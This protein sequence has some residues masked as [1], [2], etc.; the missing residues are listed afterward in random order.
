MPNHQPRPRHHPLYGF[1]LF[2]F[3]Y[4]TTILSCRARQCRWQFQLS[5]EEDLETILGEAIIH[6]LE[7]NHPI[8]DKTSIKSSVLSDITIRLPKPGNSS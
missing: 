4:T 3:A 7:C 2:R 6:R 1:K 8:Q 5:Q